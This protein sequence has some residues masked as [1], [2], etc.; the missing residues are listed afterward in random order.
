MSRCSE[1]V[2]EDRRF[3][4]EI[5]LRGVVLSH[6]TSTAG[7]PSKESVVLSAPVLGPS[8]RVRSTLNVSPGSTSSHDFPAPS[9]NCGYSVF[10][11][12]ASSRKM[13]M[14]KPV[15]GYTSKHKQTMI[16]NNAANFRK[17]LI[18]ILVTLLSTS[19]EES[20][21]WS[22]RVQDSVADAR[23]VSSHLNPSINVFL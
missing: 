16:Y 8:S 1:A 10:A 13:L 21:I 7:V 18:I 4:L 3:H 20:I 11:P 19:T 14:L 2:I 15:R 22:I 12:F 17:I 6:P 23:A 5:L 9:T